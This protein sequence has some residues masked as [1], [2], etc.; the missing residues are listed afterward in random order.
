VDNCYSGK[1]KN[2]ELLLLLMFAMIDTKNLGIE[3]NVVLTYSE[4]L[5]ITKM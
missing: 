4:I 1:G 5:I 3:I 2:V